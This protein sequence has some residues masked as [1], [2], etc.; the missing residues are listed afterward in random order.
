[1]EVTASQPGRDTARLS[2]HTTTSG[3]GVR[4][5]RYGDFLIA[6]TGL[7]PQPRSRDTIRP[8]DYRAVLRVTR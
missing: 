7:T 4:E 2:L 5:A 6:L 1:V 3:G 8:D